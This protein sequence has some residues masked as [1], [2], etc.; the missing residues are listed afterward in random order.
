MQEAGSVYISISVAKQ[1]NG[2]IGTVNVMFDPNVMRYNEIMR[3][4]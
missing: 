2:S 4:G 3:E 1:R